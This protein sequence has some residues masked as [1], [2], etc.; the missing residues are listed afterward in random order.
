[1]ATLAFWLKEIARALFWALLT[2]RLVR[3]RGSDVP[4]TELR[5]VTRALDRLALLLLMGGA[6]PASQELEDLVLGPAPEED[7]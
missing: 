5:E 3:R 1:M 7:P 4:E 6:E 2:L